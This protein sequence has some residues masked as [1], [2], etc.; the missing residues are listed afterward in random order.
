MK[1]FSKRPFLALLVSMTLVAFLPL[2]LNNVFYIRFRNTVL[3]QQKSLAEESLRFSVQQID[4]TLLELTTLAMRLDDEMWNL[5]IPTEEALNSVQRMEL[6]DVS[7]R[8][9]QE[10]ESGSEYLFALYLYSNDSNY[11]I[12][13]S[14]SYSREMLYQKF[15]QSA[16]L[17]I[18]EMDELHSTFS[19]ADL[20]SLTD[21]NMAFIRTIRKSSTGQP[22]LQLVL[23]LRKSFYTTLIDKGNVEN[24][25]FLLLN[26]DG[27]LAASNKTGIQF[28]DECLR[29]IA[30]TENSGDIRVEKEEMLLY[31][32]H[33]SIRGYQVKAIV[34]YSQL[35]GKSQELQQYY[36]ILL[37]ASVVLGMILSLL[38]SRRNVTPIRQLISYIRDHYGPDTP[39]SQGLEQIKDAVDALLDQRRTAQEQ[40]VEY[41]ALI[42]RSRLLE[43]LRG[44]LQEHGAASIPSACRYTVICFSTQSSPEE[45]FQRVIQS[46]QALPKECFCRSVIL[47]GTIVEILGMESPDFSEQKAEEF[48]TAQIE[49]LDNLPGPSFSAAFSSIHQGTDSLERA[50]GEACMAKAFAQIRPDPILTSFSNCEFKASS[51]L[52]DWHHLDKQLLF[53]TL[54]GKC[55]FKEASQLLSTLFPAEFLEEYFPESDITFLHLASLKY[56]FL[57][58]IDALCDSGNISEEQWSRL[59]QEILYC[60]NHR[61]LYQLMEQ[62]FA[63]QAHEESHSV[64][65]ASEI[66]RIGEIRQY[67]DCHYADPLLNVSSVAE[68]F[69]MSSNSLSQLFSRKADGGVLDYIHQVRIRQAAR[70]LKGCQNLTIQE[71][72]SRVGYT[73]ILT[74]NRK[75]KSIYNQTPSEYRKNTE[76]TPPDANT[77]S[78]AGN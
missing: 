64:T 22:E 1:H 72:A 77:S 78:A 68:A 12:G 24:G 40:I 59:L 5:T 18:S 49:W 42:D 45:A 47:D 66:G 52:R 63:N 48:L 4:R 74:F 3:E 65:E 27:I 62:V 44:N 25:L 76:H 56:Q 36:W 23:L 16:G 71:I 21:E 14:A 55:Q 33:S 35:L 19:Y 53:S 29:S 75:F 7:S 60:K 38:L 58:D 28:S 50:Y 57:H 73:S 31:T 67:I 69:G 32:L 2:L 13:N 30:D 70:L 6:F 11:A 46:Q 41:E 15:Y 10:L 39:N 34:P 43:M 54:V 61:H 20:V 37:A 17:S 9:R 51:F 8:L 26:T